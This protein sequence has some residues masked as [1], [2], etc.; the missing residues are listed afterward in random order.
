M[1][2]VVEVEKWAGQQAAKKCSTCST[3]PF[4]LW[5]NNFGGIKI[6][7]STA[8]SMFGVLEVQMHMLFSM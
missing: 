5:S 3:T 7:I 2:H 4:Y 1:G 8:W 6:Y